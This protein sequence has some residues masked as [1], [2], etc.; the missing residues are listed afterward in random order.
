MS[1]KKKDLWIGIVFLLIQ[2]ALI[3]P[4]MIFARSAS[5]LAN[6]KV[7]HFT[8]ELY[9][10]IYNCELTTSTGKF[11]LWTMIVMGFFMIF[12]VVVRFAYLTK[13]R[14]HSI[15]STSKTINDNNSNSTTNVVAAKRPISLPVVYWILTLSM[16]TFMMIWISTS[17]DEKPDKL[18]SINTFGLIYKNLLY[19]L[20]S[21]VITY[22]DSEKRKDVIFYNCDGQSGN[23]ANKLDG[24]AWVICSKKEKKKDAATDEVGN[25]NDV[26]TQV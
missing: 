8:S 24:E 20:I 15:V 7:T 6:W 4:E 1:S 10:E 9:P 11:R 22:T 3:I 13:N 21:Y 16:L 12:Y 18:M 5:I 25:N 23:N 26:S 17:L 14:R 2:T 19:I